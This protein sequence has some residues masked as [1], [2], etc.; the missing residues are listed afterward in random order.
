MNSLVL[1]YTSRNKQE[2]LIK[3][4]LLESNGIPAE[5]K[6]APEERHTRGWGMPVGMEDLEKLFHLSVPWE[7]ADEAKEILEA[8]RPAGA[9]G[10]PGTGETPALV[11]LDPDHSVLTGPEGLP[12]EAVEEAADPK[13][14]RYLFSYTC[15]EPFHQVYQVFLSSR[16][17]ERVRKIAEGYSWHDLKTVLGGARPGVN[18]ASFREMYVEGLLGG[19]DPPG[20]VFS[21][22][23][24][25]GNP[26]LAD[27]LL[28]LIREGKKT[29]TSSLPW[30]Y[31]AEGS[32]PPAAGDIT[33]ILD[34]DGKPGAVVRTTSVTEL[35]FSEVSPEMARLEGEDDLSLEAW[36]KGHW[37]WFSREC[38]EIG[39]TPDESMPVLFEEFELLEK[40]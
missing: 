29:A 40:V 19:F 20:C 30:S 35:P 6:L 26:R 34:G 31:R 17:A 4:H 3:K 27:R 1:V 37:K 9:A 15:G 2:L 22:E 33:V 11:L 21:A 24:F 38:K 23:R 16:P 13:T 14:F 8:R 39:M 5:V 18:P 25:G 32:T 36:R 12:L 10:G 7:A 28:A